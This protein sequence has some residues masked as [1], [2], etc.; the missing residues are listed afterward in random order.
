ML[1]KFM[2]ALTW[3]VNRAGVSR[4]GLWDFVEREDA[5]IVMLQEVTSIPDRICDRY[6]SHLVKPRY[7]GGH[8][9]PFASAV[10]AKG[11]IN[12]KPFLDSELDWVN[13]IHTERSGWILE[14]EVAV[15][16]REQIRVV[17]VHS[18]AFPIPQ[19]QWA[20]K[21]VGG[22]KLA[23]NPDLWFSQIL[24]ALLLHANLA[25][26]TSWIVGGDFNSSILFD[27]PRDR[28]NRENIAR[29][30][31][32]GLIDCL[33]SFEGQSVP[34]FQDTRKNLRHQID[35]LY[36][37]GPMR[38]RLVGACVPNPAVVFDPSPRLSD[39]LPIVCEFSNP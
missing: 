33:S 10:L 25:N 15:A 8:L 28:G 22:I 5:D 31:G 38:D 36:V 24:W 20:G 3:N 1:G 4:T 16:D 37:N 2:K 7:F 6:R 19:D 17:S 13:R 23:N 12:T 14:C 34:T 35:Y 18:P 39:H 21:D 29:L 11:S 30:N 26:G 9:A 32:L 27:Y